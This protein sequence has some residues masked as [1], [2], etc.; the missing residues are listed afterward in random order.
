MRKSIA[1]LKAA[2]LRQLGVSKPY[3]HQLVSRGR[4]P[5]LELA[6]RIERAFGIPPREWV[7]AANDDTATEKAA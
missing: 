7:E 1:S 4:Q 3:A 5:S 6:V 2:D